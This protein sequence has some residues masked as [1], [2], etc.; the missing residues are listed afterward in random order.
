MATLPNS[1]TPLSVFNAR[2]LRNWNVKRIQFDVRLNLQID[3]LVANTKLTVAQRIKIAGQILRDFV[4]I[5]LSRPVRKYRSKRTGRTVVDPKSRSV[6]GEFP[7]ADTTRLLKDIYHLFR[8]EELASYVGTRL[9]YGKILE[10]KRDRSFLR[11]SLNELR[12][13]LLTIVRG[14]HL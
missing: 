10:T 5:N 4:V 1:G 11:R 13:K 8:S 3:K 9:L 2:T 7:R 6:R 14:G 12:S